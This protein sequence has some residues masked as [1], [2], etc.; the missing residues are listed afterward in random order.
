[1]LI[2]HLKPNVI[3]RLV[4]SFGFLEDN[5]NTGPGVDQ[6]TTIELIYQATGFINTFYTITEHDEILR[7]HWSINLLTHRQVEN[8]FIY[9]DYDL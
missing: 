2:Y 5:S 7:A 8:I 3:P 1:M 4:C 6:N 9:S